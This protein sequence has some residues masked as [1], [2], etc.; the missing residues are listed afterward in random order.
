MAQKVKKSIAG[1]QKPQWKKITR[2]NL[3]PFPSKRNRRVKPNEVIRATKEELGKY[4][5]HFELVKDGTGEYQMATTAPKPA[6]APKPLKPITGGKK[7]V[8]YS[9]VGA[10][11]ELFNVVSASGKVMNASPLDADSAEELR[12]KLEKGDD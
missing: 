5:D 7:D 2:G 11:E 10:G 12:S 4:I 1:P 6:R 8:E 3:Y 9:L